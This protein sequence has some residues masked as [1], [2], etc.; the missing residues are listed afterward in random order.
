MNLSIGETLMHIC[1]CIQEQREDWRD[2]V[3]EK[4]ED[5][6]DGTFRCIQDIDE[7]EEQHSLNPQSI[8]KDWWFR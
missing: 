3:V 4:N 5:L 8:N 7:F 1:G 2:K 6:K